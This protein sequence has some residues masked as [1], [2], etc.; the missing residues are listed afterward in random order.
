MTFCAF[1]T[2]PDRIPQAD[3]IQCNP[4]SPASFQHCWAAPGSHQAPGPWRWEWLTVFCPFQSNP[5]TYSNILNSAVKVKAMLTSLFWIST[6]SLWCRCEHREPGWKVHHH[7]CGL[8]LPLFLQDE[9]SYC[10]R[11]E[12]WQGNK[13]T[14]GTASP[15]SIKWKGKQC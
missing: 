7:L 2:R 14:Y 11:Q 3:A 15:Q 9:G 10:G 1:Q 13:Y 5:I 12:G 6:T 4:Q 8:L